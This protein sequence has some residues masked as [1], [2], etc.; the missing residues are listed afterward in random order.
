MQFRNRTAARTGSCR[1]SGGPYA[2]IVAGCWER[3]SADLPAAKP[4]VGA[5]WGAVERSD[6]TEV[7][8]D[9]RRDTWQHQ[10]ALR[11]SPVRRCSEELRKFFVDFGN[12][13]L[14]GCYTPAPGPVF[15]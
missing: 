9:R 11:G 4:A 6:G 13:S 2:V 7:N 12:F 3:R 8:S 14:C 5:P 15:S 1:T 10:Q